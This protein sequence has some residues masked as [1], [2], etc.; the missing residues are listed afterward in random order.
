MKRLVRSQSQQL[1]GGVC[2]GVASVFDADPNLVRLT[3]FFLTLITAVIPGVLTYLLA[4]WILPVVSNE[5]TPEIEILP[6]ND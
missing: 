4:W 3:V 6:P 5:G 2:G 1:V